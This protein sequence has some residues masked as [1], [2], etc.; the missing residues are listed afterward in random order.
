VTILERI[1][2]TRCGTSSFPHQPWSPWTEM[3]SSSKSR[4]SSLAS[5]RG[6]RW[7]QVVAA[8]VDFPLSRAAAEATG[9]GNS[10]GSIRAASIEENDKP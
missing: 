7:W 8:R 3:P 1:T 6:L 2:L 5:T 9:E 10:N 4:E